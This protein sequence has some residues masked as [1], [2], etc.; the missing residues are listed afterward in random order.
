MRQE[1]NSPDVDTGNQV[2]STEI[3]YKPGWQI[4]TV[5]ARARHTKGQTFYLQGAKDHLGFFEAVKLSE[6]EDKWIRLPAPAQRYFFGKAVFGRKAIR[7]SPDGKVKVFQT[8]AFGH[9]WDIDTVI[10]DQARRCFVYDEPEM[11]A[12]PL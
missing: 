12:Y 6:L 8:H 1:T 3:G 11:R 9:D 4:C 5:L 10:L 2:V 7:V